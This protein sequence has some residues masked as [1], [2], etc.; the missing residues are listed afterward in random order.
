[1]QYYYVLTELTIWGGQI[2]RG[3]YDSISLVFDYIKANPVGYGNTY[4]AWQLQ[5]ANIRE[6]DLT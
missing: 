2:D 5:V 4:R 3:F 1:M 6:Y